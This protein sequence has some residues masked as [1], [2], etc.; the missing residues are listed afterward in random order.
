SPFWG[1][2][3]DG[4]WIFRVK[5]P[6]C[7]PPV[8]KAHYVARGFSQRQGVD[9]FQTFYPALNMTNLLVLLHVAVQRDYEVHSL[10]FIT[11]FLQGSLHEE[12]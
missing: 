4:M 8:F 6:P 3:I 12:I 9:F 10:D 7:S 2:H 5:R 1:E 11:V